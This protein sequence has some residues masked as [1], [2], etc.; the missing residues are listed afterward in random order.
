MEQDLPKDAPQTQSS[1]QEPRQGPLTRLAKFDRGFTLVRSLSLV[2]A[3]SSLLV[4]YFQYLNSYQEK[5][6]AQAK[7][8]MEYAA[9]TF[10]DIATKFS[11][12]QTLQQQLFADYSTA[13]DDRA[14]ANDQ[15]LA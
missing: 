7:E 13:L 4:G 8:N 2:G 6:N 9:K 15:A 12:V 1:P 3:L 5:V 11:Q 14:D 10:D